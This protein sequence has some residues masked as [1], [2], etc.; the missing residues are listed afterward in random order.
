L[1]SS[2][3][4][5]IPFWLYFYGAG[6]TGNKKGAEAPFYYQLDQQIS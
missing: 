4:I 1:C 6:N 3:F 5:F 2:L